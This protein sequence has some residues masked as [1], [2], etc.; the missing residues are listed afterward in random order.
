[1]TTAEVINE[2]NRKKVNYTLT[3]IT[4]DYLNFVVGQFVWASSVEINLRDMT[5]KEVHGLSSH[6]CTEKYISEHLFLKELAFKVQ[7]FSRMGAIIYEPT[8]QQ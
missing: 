7:H 8:N 5:I 2:L 4:D 1:M 6:I 3:K